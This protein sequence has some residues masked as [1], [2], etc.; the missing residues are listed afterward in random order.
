MARPYD[1]SIVN[2]I[3]TEQIVNG[4]YNVT[5]VATGYDPTSLAPTTE[6]VT[7]ERDAYP[8]TIAATGTLTL[9]VTETG[10]PTVP[11]SGALFRRCDSAG[12]QYGTP[13]TTDSNGDAQFL[14]VP[15]AASGAPNIYFKQLASDGNHDYN[16][17]TQF[18][19]M[20][21]DSETFEINNTLASS[22]TITL[23]D[24]NY[25]DLPVDSATI[26]FS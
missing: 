5:V 16:G 8:F 21:T 2:G 22:K 24:A 26:T 6:I 7:T 10:A 23:R 20:A 4:T 3:G 18:T 12:M 19:T 14:N 9:H 17:E 11:I 1:I 25:T 13:I 15:F